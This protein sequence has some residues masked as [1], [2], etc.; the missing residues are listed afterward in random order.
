ME[1]RAVTGVGE[2]LVDV[3]RPDRVTRWRGA[4]RSVLDQAVLAKVRAGRLRDLSW[5]YGLRSVVAVGCVLFALTA[6]L[7][8]LS[9]LIRG[10]SELTVPNSL[11]SSVPD[12]LVWVL[13]FLLAFCL[14]LL[15]TAAI[16]GPWWLRTLGLLALILLL[17]VWSAATTTTRGLTGAVVAAVVTLLVMVALILLRRRRGLAWWEFPLV[18]G[19]IGSV[20]VLCTRDFAYTDRL[21][22]FRLLP[23]FV[24]QTITLLVF[25]VLPAAFAA[26]AAVAEIAV[27]LTMAATRTAQRRPVGRWPYV[28]LGAVVVIRLAQEARRLADLDPV[29]SGW[30]AVLPALGLVAAF[31]GLAWLVSRLSPLGSVSV[32]D[33]PDELGR[34]AV[35]VG[36]AVIGLML[37][38][39]VL[40]F[41]WQIVV[42]VSPT[43]AP[44][45]FDPS[46]L[47]DRLVDGFRLVLGAVLVGAALWRARQGRT[48]VA[49][50]LGATGVVVFATG[51]R[52]LTGY[53][54]AL[55]LDP[56][57]LISVVTVGLL[58][59]AGWLL[60]RRR[61]SPARALGLAAVLV[62]AVLLSVRSVLVDP[63]G[64][65]LGYGGVAFVLFGVVWDF[66]TS[67]QWANEDGR[68]VARPVRVLLAL[69]Y[70]LLTV[71]VVA[72][73]ALIRRPRTFSDVTA[74]AELGE[75][76]L[77][78]GLL[79]AAAV[80]VLSAVRGDRDVA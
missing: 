15:T 64:A 68:R 16:H 8:L 71:T 63:F 58:V 20:L 7:A 35:P 80:V 4:A 48:G 12:D 53:R 56:D 1:R 74:F 62:L 39:Y 37:P 18:L 26:G 54:W 19:L 29:E 25:L 41:G 52:L 22:G 34:I 24:D 42:S 13:V 5:P 49:L 66:L 28:V 2:R 73:D 65:L 51:L 50:V 59:A 21:L 6:V 78:T 27:G 47:V 72:A 70:P 44:G 23:V 46:P 77:G 61:L 40:I 9:G 30:I 75:L 60:A 3:D 14:S 69:G 55:W 67:S 45:G 76:V 43:G 36:A 79:A 33:L 17:G 11:S 38:V 57:A 31:A 32:T 10:W